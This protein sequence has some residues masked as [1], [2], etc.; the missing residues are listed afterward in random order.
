VTINIE[1]GRI[2]IW[3][4]SGAYGEPLDPER[5]AELATSIRAVGLLN[6]ITVR[7]G[8]LYAVAGEGFLIV[9]GRHRYEAM[10][11]L[12]WAEIP[13]NVI[14]LDDL[15]AELASLDENI[16]RQQIKGVALSRILARRKE[17]YE[18]L[19][20]E[21]RAGV[22]GAVASNRA[23]GKGDA[24]EKLS[25]AS[26]SEATASATGLNKRTIELHV[27]RA[28]ALGE[29]A[30]KIAGTSLDKGV[31]IAVLAKMPKAERAP[32][33]AKAAAG[34]KVSARAVTAKPPDDDEPTA[35]SMFAVLRPQLERASHVEIRKLR[36]LINAFSKWEDTDGVSLDQ[37]P[38]EQAA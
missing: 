37:E 23:Q 11:K 1:R 12:G 31:E 33:I 21:T 4:V 24:S 5:V 38:V 9:S 2:G 32:I 20:P 27:A 26:F 28:K 19:N 36:S 34:E 7:P 16:V 6:P 17:I 18:A 3:H 35:E 8:S 10:K 22:A 14:E 30:D 29:D 15:R 25:L 13:C